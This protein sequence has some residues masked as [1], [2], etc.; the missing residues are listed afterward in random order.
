MRGF[1]MIVL[2]K[3]RM[4]FIISTVMV[5]ILSVGLAYKMP[6]AN[7]KETVALPVSNKVVILDARAPEHQMREQK[8]KMVL[9]KTK[10]IWQ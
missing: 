7:T 10:L 1:F 5:S 6:T 8:V 9:Q 2:S 3:K 4:V